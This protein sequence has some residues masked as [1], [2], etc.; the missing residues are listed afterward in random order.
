MYDHTKYVT[1]LSNPSIHR[2]TSNLSLVEMLPKDLS[3]LIKHKDKRKS[4][5]IQKSRFGPG[6]CSGP[7]GGRL[8]WQ[9]HPLSAILVLVSV[10]SSLLI[11]TSKLTG[12]CFW[13]RT[14]ACVLLAL[15]FPQRAEYHLEGASQPTSFQVKLCLT[16]TFH[17]HC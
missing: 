2:K 7:Q 5:D 14:M 11:P 15:S 10:K 1:D 6:T 13:P 3:R 16:R 9:P 8:W 4:Q 17:R 12:V